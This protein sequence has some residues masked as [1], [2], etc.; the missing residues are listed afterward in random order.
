MPDQQQTAQDIPKPP[1]SVAAASPD[2]E[3]GVAGHLGGDKTQTAQTQQPAAA[4]AAQP[5]KKP[6]YDG[7][8]LQRPQSSGFM[9]QLTGVVNQ[10]KNLM[11]SDNDDEE[12]V[13]GRSKL[14]LGDKTYWNGMEVADVDYDLDHWEMPVDTYTDPRARSKGDKVAEPPKKGLFSKILKRSDINARMGAWHD[15]TQHPE[16]ASEFLKTANETDPDEFLPA[17]AASAKETFRPERKY[18]MKE[19]KD[20][21]NQEIAAPIKSGYDSL[22]AAAQVGSNSIYYDKN[23]QNMLRDSFRS[24]LESLFDQG[25]ID[26][27]QLDDA[28]WEYDHSAWRENETG[29]R[30]L[31]AESANLE[32]SDEFLR[33]GQP[34]ASFDNRNDVAHSKASSD[35]ATV[36]NEIDYNPLMFAMVERDEP[37]DP[38][39]SYFGRRKARYFNDPKT[40]VQ[41]YKNKKRALESDAEKDEGSEEKVEYKRDEQLPMNEVGADKLNRISYDPTGWEATEDH[42]AVTPQKVANWVKEQLATKNSDDDFKESAT[43][44]NSYL[45]GLQDRG[46]ITRDQAEFARSPT[47]VFDT[48]EASD[49]LRDKTPEGRHKRHKIYTQLDDADKAI[50]GQGVDPI[51]AVKDNVA[52]LGHGNFAY[53]P[54]P[55]GKLVVIGRQDRDKPVYDDNGKPTGNKTYSKTVDAADIDGIRKR[56]ADKEEIEKELADIRG[57][58]R[59]TI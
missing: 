2:Y 46:Y 59:S 16:R 51:K 1:K 8:G 19:S 9:Q 54:S 14:T 57:H 5:K 30:E 42:Y 26:D 28:M 27:R 6:A 33:G 31:F 21:R 56:H 24:Y 15:A 23:M 37:G 7:P 47:F 44:L 18:D 48:P 35:L 4:P 55:K 45:D 20:L 29:G 58:A 36:L 3:G 10:G 53:S 12:H 34:V 22:N 41:A 40:A 38:S 11:R 50:Q 25:K 32:K 49:M 43:L 13:A 39:L 52:S 17:M